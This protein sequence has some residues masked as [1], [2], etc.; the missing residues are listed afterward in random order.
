MATENP[1]L[2]SIIF[3]LNA[4]FIQFWWDFPGSYVWL[5][6]GDVVNPIISHPINQPFGVI[7]QGYT[8]PN[9]KPLLEMVYY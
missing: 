2:V 1:H 3:P 8:V 9:N 7:L 6:E 5:S 4:N